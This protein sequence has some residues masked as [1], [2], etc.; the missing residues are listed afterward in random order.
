VG[1]SSRKNRKFPKRTVEIG[2]WMINSNE[3]FGVQGKDSGN[4]K[5]K[6]SVGKK[7]MTCPRK[8]VGL[9]N[10]FWKLYSLIT[11]S[12]GTSKHHIIQTSIKINS[13]N[14]KT[15]IFLYLKL[16][17][18]KL[19]LKKIMSILKSFILFR[20]FYLQPKIRIF[21]V[22]QYYLFYCRV[23]HANMKYLP[24]YIHYRYIT[25]GCCVLTC[26]SKRF[27]MNGQKGSVWISLCSLTFFTLEFFRLLKTQYKTT[28]WRKSKS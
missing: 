18:L 20:V 6:D 21:G 24:V 9:L 16:W 19:I 3:W 4:S 1:T 26:G 28:H 14:L 22:W 7:T 15:R 13:E 11:P 25:V 27:C 5:P 2:W 17:K 8:K 12:Q 10:V 23:L